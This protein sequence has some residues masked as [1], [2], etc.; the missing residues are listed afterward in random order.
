MPVNP[1]KR[2][3]KDGTQYIFHGCTVFF[4]NDEQEDTRAVF[5]ILP[6][7]MLA[8]A[9]PMNTLVAKS[10]SPNEVETYLKTLPASRVSEELGELWKKRQERTS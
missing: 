7:G 4:C 8:I 10:L 3:G 5:I 1:D 2:P 9:G 6:E